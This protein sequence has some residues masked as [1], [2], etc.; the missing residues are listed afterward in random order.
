M[1]IHIEVNSETENETER[2]F[3]FIIMEINIKDYFK[4]IKSQEKGS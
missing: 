1:E 4:I 2:V 3:T